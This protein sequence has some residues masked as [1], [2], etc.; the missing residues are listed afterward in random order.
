MARPLEGRE[1]FHT[2]DLDEA[3]DLVARAFCSHKLELLDG[4]IDVRRHSAGL[5][6][7]SLHY[8]DYGADV[9]ISPQ[10]LESFFLLQMPMAGAAQAASPHFEVESSPEVATMLSPDVPTT[11]RWTAGTPHLCLRVDREA[12]EAKAARMIGRSLRDPLRFDLGVRMDTPE[13]RSMRHYIDLLRLE[14]ETD[15]SLSARP[16]VVGQLEDLIMTS[17]LLGARH[18]YSDRLS[19]EPGDAAPRCVR[20]AKEIIEDHAHE[21]LTVEDIAESVGMSVRSLQA[22][23]QRHTGV[24]PMAYLRDVRLELVHKALVTADSSNGITV[25]DI[26]LDNGFTHLGRFA[27]VYRARFGAS[28]S[29]TLKS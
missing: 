2:R 17:L 1:A 21:P 3:R 22:G 9:R 8:L 16:V 10:P 12:L 19:A 7:L 14:L 27:Q 25:T 26:A 11:M 24:S 13:T 5:P 6:H 28:P 4:H 23:F 15:E 29:E 20:R 18:N